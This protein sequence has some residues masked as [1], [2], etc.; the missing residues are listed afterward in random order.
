MK[1]K[2]V[3]LLLVAAMTGTMV[4]GCGSKAD[5]K[6]ADTK[7]EQTDDK[8]DTEE[9]KEL[10]DDEYQYVSAADTVIADGVHVL[11]VREWENYSKGRVANSEWCPIFPLE[12]DSLVDEMTTYAKDHLND[13]KDIYVICN[14]G[15]RG[16]EKA[17]AVLR[18][19]GIESTSIYT[20]E[21]GAK[22]LA[23]VSGALTTDRTEENIDWQYVSG[24]DAVAAVDDKD[25]QIL[26]VR[27][28][29]TYKAGHLKGSFQC[30]LKEVESADAQTAMYKLATEKMDSSKKVY[31]LC[32]SGNKCAKTGISILKDAG[33]DLDNLYIIENGAKDGDVSAAFVTE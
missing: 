1:K 25:V 26:D 30:G 33:F 21:G 5:D 27:D 6:T 18:D 28:D 14:S 12:D 16:A 19:A 20:V 9:K 7:T 32:Y 17:T 11:D 31:L 22:A 13:G 29:D 2:I 15:K 8:K 23:D 24:K 4:V 10:A 3:T